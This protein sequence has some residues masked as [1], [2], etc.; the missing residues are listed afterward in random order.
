MRNFSDRSHG[1]K[2][3]DVEKSNQKEA[4]LTHELGKLLL[5]LR[6]V[7]DETSKIAVNLIL[8]LFERLQ[9]LRGEITQVL[10]G[11]ICVR[12]KLHNRNELQNNPCHVH[13]LYRRGICQNREYILSPI[14]R[15]LD[16]Q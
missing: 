7:M 1:I 16:I 9:H 2:R 6:K 14:Y 12:L 13:S 10:R 5:N 8:E 11:V 4:A 3:V 15:I